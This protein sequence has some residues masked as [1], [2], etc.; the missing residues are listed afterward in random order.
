MW[1]RG[2]RCLHGM[3]TPPFAAAL[4]GHPFGP[5][6]AAENARDLRV[7]GRALLAVQ[8][9][10]R[11]LPER[12]FLASHNRQLSALWERARIVAIRGPGTPNKGAGNPNTITGDHVGLVTRAPSARP[13]RPLGPNVQW[14]TPTAA[15]RTQTRTS[16]RMQSRAACV[17]DAC[18]QCTR[19][20]Q[21]RHKLTA[22]AS[23]TH[24]HQRS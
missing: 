2:R 23:C 22:D 1:P 21:S 11:D 9:V 15:Q 19:A 3:Q 10:Q 4:A 5:L 7:P 16:S 24:S 18:A 13:H 14:R 17:H 12:V 8:L 6:G 20:P